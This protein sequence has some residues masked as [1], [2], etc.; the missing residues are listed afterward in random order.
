[1][2]S[3]VEGKARNGVNKMLWRLLLGIMVGLIGVAGLGF[4]TA[5]AFLA[6]SAVMSAAWAALLIG[7]GLLLVAVGCVAIAKKPWS[8]KGLAN[9]PKTQTA[10]AMDASN[11]A[12]TVAFTAAFVLGRYLGGDKP[13]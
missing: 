7:L 5:S 9:A 4:L 3:A 12:P 1:M 11:V 13:G 10:A 6:L 8:K 2:M